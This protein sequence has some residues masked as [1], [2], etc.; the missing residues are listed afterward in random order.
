MIYVERIYD[1]EGILY[2]TRQKNKPRSKWYG[3]SIEREGDI[4]PVS[5][6]DE[7]IIEIPTMS[8]KKLL[9][10]CDLAPKEVD[11]VRKLVKKAT[12]LGWFEK[13]SKGTNFIL[14]G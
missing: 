7:F 2:I 12:K 4:T 13:P 5:D 1:D 14:Q 10:E 8:D 6:N 9:L 3:V 11:L